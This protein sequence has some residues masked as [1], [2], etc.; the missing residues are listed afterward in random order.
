MPDYQLASMIV[1]PEAEKDYPRIVYGEG[2]YLYDEDGN[3]YIDVSG[4]SAAVSSIGHGNREIADILYAQACKVSILPTHYFSS[5]VVEKYMKRLVAFCPPGFTRAWTVSSGTEAVENA[6]KVAMQYHQL[7]KQPQRYKLIGRWGSYH[8]NSI[9]T[10]DVG[11]MRIRRASYEHLLK[12]HPHIPPAYC[13]R[14]PFGLHRS[15]CHLECA[16]SLEQVI[17]EEGPETVAGFLVEPVVGAAL[18]SLPAP[19]G[20]FARIREICD[21]YG[22]LLIADE[23]MTGFCRTG[24]NFGIENWDVIPDIIAAGKGIASGYYPLSAIM[25]HEK[26]AHVF[27]EAK[28]PFLGGHTYACN[29][30]GAAVGLYV[31]DFMERERICEYVAETGLFFLDSLQQL[32]QYPII[33]DVRGM[34]LLCGFEIVKDKHTKAPFDKDMQVARQVGLEALKRGVILYPGRGSV[35]GISGDHVLLAPPLIITQEQLKRV[36]EVIK[37]SIAEVCDRVCR[38]AALSKSGDR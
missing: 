27:D 31:L 26:V 2:V 18:G 5:P 28:A 14:C 37:E 12:C 24:K 1:C 16:S 22:I 23:V 19:D 25:L 6:L 9:L 10:L 33:G 13:Y 36:V 21:K 29:P 3:R 7:K 11:G 34:G 15:C 17:L 4:G 8:G 30:L 35:D 32:Y 20:Y 38:G